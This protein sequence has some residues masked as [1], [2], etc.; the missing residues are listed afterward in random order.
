MIS[1]HWGSKKVAYYSLLLSGLC[2]VAAPF[3]F[4]FSF[5]F[6]AALLLVWGF[7]VTS[8][9]PQFSAL[10]TKSV[11]EKNKG[12][13][14]TIVTSLGFAITILSIHLLKEL[15]ESYGPK[16]ILVLCL[17]PLFGL[18]SLKRPE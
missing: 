9:S 4:Q 16:S 6:F 14:L 17:G 11:D 2:C 12:T 13:A 15:F 3:F 10:V 5:S 8:D 7:A 18:L 1:Q